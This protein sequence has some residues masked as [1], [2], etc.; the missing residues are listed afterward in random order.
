MSRTLGGVQKV[1]TKKKFVRSFRSL[2]RNVPPGTNPRHAG[3]VSWGINFL[4]EY[5]RG[6]YSHSREYRNIFLRNCFR[7]MYSHLRR[8]VFSPSPPLSVWIQFHTPLMPIHKNIFGELFSVRIHAAHAFAPGRIQEN[9]P[10]ELFMYWFR[11][12]GLNLDWKDRNLKGLVKLPCPSFPCL[13]FIKENPPNLPRIFCPCRTHKILGKDREN[14]NLS[15]EMP[16]LKFTKA[17]LTSKERKDRVGFL[18]P[19]NPLSPR[20]GSWPL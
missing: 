19:R 8:Y 4:H 7:N 6:L 3:K 15:K 12:R 16:C 1:C 5:M 11:A 20:F 2:F 9:I 10:G 18:R 17:I 14:T 13:V